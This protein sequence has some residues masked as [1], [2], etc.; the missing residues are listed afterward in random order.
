MKIPYP[1]FL[2]IA[3]FSIGLVA[4]SSLQKGAPRPVPAPNPAPAADN[5]PPTYTPTLV[6][7]TTRSPAQF[8][9]LSTS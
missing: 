5:A 7:R 1:A 8:N 4:C 6:I 9:H 2:A 3:L